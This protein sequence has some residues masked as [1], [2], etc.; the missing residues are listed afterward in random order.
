[1]Q[2][3]RVL[4][5]LVFALPAPSGTIFTNLATFSSATG[6]IST[7]TF[8]DVAVG[9]MA[10]FSSGGV[11][12]SNSV[13]QVYNNVVGL[14]DSNWFG[15]QGSTPNFLLVS[16]FSSPLL[17]TFSSSTAAFGFIFT[18]FACDTLANDAG[19]HWILLSASQTV[20]DS[21]TTVFNLGPGFPSINAPPNFLGISSTV[22]F[23][24]VQIQ[25]MLQSTGNPSG[26]VWF[27]DTVSVA[28]TSPEPSTVGL[29]GS[30]L[31]GLMWLRRRSRSRRNAIGR[32]DGS[33]EL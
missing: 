7:A 19:I 3:A 5:F 33:I 6:G 27:M 21:G 32:I 12:V 28:S 30:G 24:S 16:T 2:W 17:L 31:A 22:P 9:T 1:M 20:I 23:V 14:A 11:S 4:I 18:C 25:R 10:P 15:G 26:G 29:M 8:D 13:A